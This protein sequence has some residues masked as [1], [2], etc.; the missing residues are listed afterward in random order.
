MSLNAVSSLTG[1]DQYQQSGADGI[2]LPCIRDVN[3]IETVVASTSLPIN[4]MCIPELPSFQE[5]KTL[6]VKRISMGNFVYEAMLASLSSS[7]MS[8]KRE[9]SF[10]TLFL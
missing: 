2:F 7:L 5:L 1:A 8:I 3:D 9:R 4:V 10:Q 6:G